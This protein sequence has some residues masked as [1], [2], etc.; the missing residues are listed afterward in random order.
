[1][2]NTAFE[3]LRRGEKVPKAFLERRIAAA[4]QQLADRTKARQDISQ[5]YATDWSQIQKASKDG[6]DR[7]AKRAME[8]VLKIHRNLAKKKNAA[9]ARIGLGGIVS[10][11]VFGVRITPPFD[12][13]FTLI[14]DGTVGSPTLDGSAY[15]NSGQISIVSSP[16]T[17]PKATASS[18]AKSAFIFA[19]DSGRRLWWPERTHRVLINGGQIPLGIA[20]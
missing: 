16:M 19:R 14:E 5:R 2:H 8:D 11:S 15:K 7:R 1:M 10:T 6:D 17:R 12:Y 4:K 9:S 20:E 18:T 3:F 13:A